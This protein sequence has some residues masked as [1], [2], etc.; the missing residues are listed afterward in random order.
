[1]KDYGQFNQVY[2]NKTL[3]SAEQYVL[4]IRDIWQEIDSEMSLNPNQFRDK[5][6]LEARFYLPQKQLLLDNKDKDPKDQDPQ[7]QAPTIRSKLISE[8]I[9]KYIKTKGWYTLGWPDQ[10]WRRKSC[11]VWF[12]SVSRILKICYKKEKTINEFKSNILLNTKDI[13]KY[14]NSQHLIEFTKIFQQLKNKTGRV[15]TLHPIKQQICE[16]I[17]WPCWP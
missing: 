6:N 11:K 15:N 2:C 14:G 3:K 10:Y 5:E 1:M 8:P 7:I 9:L 13:R 17:W 16:T 12:H 4:D